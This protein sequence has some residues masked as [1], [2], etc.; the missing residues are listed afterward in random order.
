MNSL[1]IKA[2]AKINLSLSVTGRREDGYHNIDTVMQ[3]VSLYDVL[4]VIKADKI[5]VECGEMSGEKN[6]AFKAARLFFEHIET[7]GGAFIQIEKNIPEEAGLGG[8]SAD[9][10][11]VL[12]GLDRIYNTGLSY[13]TLKALAVRL[14]ADVPFMLRGGTARA[15]GIGEV[16][17]PLPA[18]WDCFFIIAK[19]RKRFNVKIRFLLRIF[20]LSAFFDTSGP[21]KQRP[22]YRLCLFLIF[23]VY[24]YHTIVFCPQYNTSMT[25][26][27]AV[28]R[29]GPKFVITERACLESQATKPVGADA[30]IILRP[31]RDRMNICIRNGQ[32]RPDGCVEGQGILLVFQ[33]NLSGKKQNRCKNKDK[34]CEKRRPSVEGILFFNGRFRMGF[35]VLFCISIR[36]QD[37]QHNR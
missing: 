16:L 37:R 9:A 29:I 21:V 36:I 22:V 7:D 24:D 23:S 31:I 6:I 14:G 19:K 26:I 27:I 13:E 33:C 12:A 11:A 8:G 2:A 3:S 28:T 25:G 30:D 17:E 5:T 1:K 4:T 32:I 34:S 18:L 15:T 20:L 10:A 35:S